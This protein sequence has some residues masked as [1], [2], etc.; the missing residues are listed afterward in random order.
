MLLFGTLASILL[1][2]A[3]PPAPLQTAPSAPNGC[4]VLISRSEGLT[5]AESLRVVEQVGGAL[6]AAGVPVRLA[7]AEVTAR[8][9]E[10]ISACAGGAPCLAGVGRSLG[11][12]AV[13]AVDVARVFGD[14]SYELALL[15]VAGAAS[16]ADKV[17]AAPEGSALIDAELADFSRTARYAL[18]T[19]PAFNPPAPD[20]PRATRL[21]PPVPSALRDVP[22][23]RP[24][25]LAAY[26]ATG[27]AVVAGVAAGIFG[28]MT[29]EMWSR[30]LPDSQNRIALRQGE[31]SS[32][33]RSQQ[34]T[35]I[36]GGA[37]AALT[38]AAVFF[39][40]NLPVEGK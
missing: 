24:L 31:L 14:L 20:S 38:S 36:A 3:P 11:A 28:A 16:L 30:T 8:A 33:Q 23:A 2:Q 35:A 12:G 19:L 10:Q 13:A 32:Y 18:L 40:L 26:A 6:S 29:L 22:A 34:F 27:G 4:V 15:E 39:W 17:F 5:S 1:A 7:P 9:G 37:C 25:P 21:T